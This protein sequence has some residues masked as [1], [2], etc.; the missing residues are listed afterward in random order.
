MKLLDK[1]FY[2]LSVKL[3]I[4]AKFD[5]DKNILEGMTYNFVSATS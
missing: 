4:D 3:T 2:N 5:T 1:S